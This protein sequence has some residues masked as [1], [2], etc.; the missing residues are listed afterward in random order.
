MDYRRMSDTHFNDAIKNG[1]RPHN[2]VV[3]LYGENTLA[4]ESALIDA[5]DD[6]TAEWSWDEFI[7][8]EYGQGITNTALKALSLDMKEN[9]H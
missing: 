9:N 8:W 1:P 3:R 6:L 4:I 2:P 7:S 5:D